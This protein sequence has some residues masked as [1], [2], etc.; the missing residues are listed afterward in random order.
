VR[1]IRKVIQLKII[2]LNKKSRKWIIWRQ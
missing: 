2:N 1:M